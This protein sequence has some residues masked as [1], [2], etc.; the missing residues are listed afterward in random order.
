MKTVLRTVLSELE[1]DVD[2]PEPE[3]PTMRHIT[4][5]PAKGARAVVVGRRRL[6]APAAE[7]LVVAG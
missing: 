4:F 6:R 1:L 7:S 3:K 2:T 5:V